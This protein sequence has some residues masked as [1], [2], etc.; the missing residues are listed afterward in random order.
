MNENSATEKETS[1]EW[2]MPE[3][4]FRSSEGVSPKKHSADNILELPP[5]EEVP[6]EIR[7]YVSEEESTPAYE[8][9][10]AEET[11]D[12]VA[13]S[14]KQTVRVKEKSSR[15]HHKKKRT[16]SK[17]MT[18]LALAVGLLIGGII[19]AVIYFLFR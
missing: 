4:V 5:D 8:P 9:I 16:Q 17:L 7:S 10:A 13:E 6:T 12:P 3:P 1:D 15:R 18:S 14:L 2:T 11:M 19:L